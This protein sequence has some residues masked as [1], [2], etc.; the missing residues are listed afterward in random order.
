[1]VIPCS[2]QA[3]LPNK[4]L[5]K[6]WPC[7]AGIQWQA[8]GITIWLIHTRPVEH[9][10]IRLIWLCALANAGLKVR[11][12]QKALSFSPHP[13]SWDSSAKLCI[14]WRMS[15]RQR[16][17]SCCNCW[18]LAPA[19][20][21]PGS[22][23]SWKLKTSCWCWILAI[24]SAS[25]PW[26]HRGRAPSHIVKQSWMACQVCSSSV[27]SQLWFYPAASLSIW[28]SVTPAI[29]APN[30]AVSS[31]RLQLLVRLLPFLF[32]FVFPVSSS[33]SPIHS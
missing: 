12:Q 2:S 22:C 20:S 14:L 3:C 23:V 27:K 6:G 28:V 1:M 15:S 7:R 5:I 25:A 17:M 33:A 4:F 10:T 8:E 16:K 31:P 11:C 13:Q 26:L 21:S 24:C 9:I 19:T 18:A 29:F 32:F 30:A